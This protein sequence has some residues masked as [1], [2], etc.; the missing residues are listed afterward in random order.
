LITFEVVEEKVEL[1]RE[2]FRL[3]EVEDVVELIKGDARQYLNDYKGVSF[4]F[5]DAEKEIY[6]EC[7][8]KIVPSMTK[9]G[10]LVADN[11]I[12]HK[13]ILKKM[14]EDAMNDQRV[15]AM[16]VPIGSGVLFCIRK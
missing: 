1:A 5:L 14:V 10:I 13:E 3:A 9:N 11:V 2:T 7:Y 6:S 4:C 12:S 16:V 8:E 15:D